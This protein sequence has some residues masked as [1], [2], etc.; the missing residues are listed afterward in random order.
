M[1]VQGSGDKQVPAIQR[2]TGNRTVIRRCNRPMSWA[3]RRA[4]VQSP[5]CGLVLSFPGLQ[6]HN[7]F[8]TRGLTFL[9][10]T[11]P[12]LSCGWDVGKGGSSDISSQVAWPQTSI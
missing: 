9:F 6:T 5:E 2:Q 4:G 1:R 12:V 7:H 11:G 8:L 3:G 10:C